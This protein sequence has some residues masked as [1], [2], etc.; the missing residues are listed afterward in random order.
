MSNVIKTHPLIQVACHL[1]LV[2]LWG[3][4]AVTIG[5]INEG[6]WGW[7]A[8]FAVGLGLLLGG[9]YCLVMESDV[10]EGDDDDMHFFFYGVISM[11]PFGIILYNNIADT[12]L[13]YNYLG[14]YLGLFLL[15]YNFKSFSASILLFILTI[16]PL[17]VMS[18]FTK[19]YDYV[20]VGVISLTGIIMT[21][22]TAGK[23]VTNSTDLEDDDERF[24][25]LF[26]F[27]GWIIY[28][29]GTAY[30]LMGNKILSQDWLSIPLII[31]PLLLSLSATSR[32]VTIMGGVI[33][34]IVYLFINWHSISFDFIK[35]W[36]GF[37]WSWIINGFKWIGTEVSSISFEWVHS[38][39][40]IY[41]AC[42][43]G[44]LFGIG[45]IIYVIYR[46]LPTKVIYVERSVERDHKLPMIY[47]GL[48]M[49]CPSCQKTIVKGEYSQSA[50]RG[51]IK[52]TT[53]GVIGGASV[54]GAFWA[55]A[56]VGGP[57]APLT[58][59]IAAVG[60]GALNYYNNKNIDGAIDWAIDKWDYEVDGGRTVYFKCP[61]HEC[62]H[63]WEETE[64]YGEIDH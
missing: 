63:T 23:S 64:H 54:V 10:S 2:F 31:F 55:G 5:H 51:I 20:I 24:I 34:S 7:I 59:A 17:Y 61:R 38:T 33:G 36:F 21:L 1:T 44:G 53:K 47:N 39:W 37:L 48:S 49:T 4:W 19:W 3:Y 30:Y 62:G 13:S 35:N 29:L 18:S 22:M 57:F 6:V 56:A 9:G 50:A 43:V 41:T 28:T 12:T 60:A 11:I 15:L 27:F 52:T 16:I 25:L 26:C 14:L 8:L 32:I 42:I 40:F 45:L 58:G 46:L